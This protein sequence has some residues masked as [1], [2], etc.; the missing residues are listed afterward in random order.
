MPRHVAM[1]APTITTPASARARRRRRSSWSRLLLPDGKLDTT[2]P[3][4]ARHRPES[5]PRLRSRPSRATG[6][7]VFQPAVKANWEP[8]GSEGVRS[9]PDAGRA[10]ELPQTGGEVAHKVLEILHGVEIA[11]EPEVEL[12]V[13]GDDR[14]A[15]AEVG[16]ERHHRE[17]VGQLTAVEMER[18]LRPGNV[19]HAKVDEALPGH[20]SGGL[21]EQ[22]GRREAAELGQRV[23]S[24]GLPGALDAHIC[25]RAASAATI[26]R[27]PLPPETPTSSEFVESPLP[28]SN[29]RPLP[30]HGGPAIA[31]T[32]LQRYKAAA[33]R[34]IAWSRQAAAT[35]TIRHTGYPPGYP[36]SRIR[37]GAARRVDV[38]VRDL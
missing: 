26:L 28:D 1:T 11:D 21:V 18:E 33:Q 6:V 13:V 2:R 8:Y 30:H 17:H 22:G 3:T 20:E 9:G 29:R 16:T 32:P 23:S 31:T 4:A 5:T 27:A 14:D 10:G 7:A 25:T 36:A 15:E 38:F 37:I 12:A 35:G 19:R 34:G 24:H